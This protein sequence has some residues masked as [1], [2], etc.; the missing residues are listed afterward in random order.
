MNSSEL[1]VGQEA[2]LGVTA[3]EME[4]LE[5]VDSEGL[6]DYRQYNQQEISKGETICSAS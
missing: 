2:P 6:G 5:K 1:S 4:V 3:E